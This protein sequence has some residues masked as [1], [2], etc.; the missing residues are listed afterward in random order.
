MADIWNQVPNPKGSMVRKVQQLFQKYMTFS[1][2]LFHGRGI[3]QYD[4]GVL[5]FRR[6]LT[7]VVG[8]PIECPKVAFPTEDL[9]LEYQRK[10]LTALQDLYD[11]HKDEYAADRKSELRFIE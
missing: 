3:F 7:T 4:L 1:P 6:P 10:Y 8:A 9:V 11:L 5:P 2:P